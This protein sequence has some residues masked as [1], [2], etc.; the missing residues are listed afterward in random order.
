MF[1]ESFYN[2]IHKYEWF[3]YRKGNPTRGSF[4]VE[5]VFETCSSSKTPSITTQLYSLVALFIVWHEFF[6]LNNCAVTCV[7]VSSFCGTWHTER[8]DFTQKN[9]VTVSASEFCSFDCLHVCSSPHYKS[10][11]MLKERAAR[12]IFFVL[13]A[14]KRLDWSSFFPG[15]GLHR[16][17]LVSFGINMRLYAADFTCLQVFFLDLVCMHMCERI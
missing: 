10:R 14:L 7:V 4:L 16:E 6:L 11:S 3:I 15:S 9:K 2:S 17:C 8:A 13:N 12:A 5:F 1:Y